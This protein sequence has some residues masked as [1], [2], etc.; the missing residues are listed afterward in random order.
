MSRQLKNRHQKYMDE[1]D[2]IKFGQGL[3]TPI[4]NRLLEEMEKERLLFPAYR[5]ICPREYIEASWK[6]KEVD[7]DLW[8][9]IVTFDR[10]MEIQRIPSEQTDEKLLGQGHPLDIAWQSQKAFIKRPEK[11][12][13]HPWKEYDVTLEYPDG[14]KTTRKCAWA[15]YEPWQIYHL[16]EITT[17][18]LGQRRWALL[19][20]DLSQYTYTM[21]MFKSSVMQYQDMHRILA[22]YQY[23]CQLHFERAFIRAESQESPFIEGENHREYKKNIHSEGVEAFKKATKE[24]WIEFIRDLSRLYSI[25]RKGKRR[26]E[27]CCA[28]RSL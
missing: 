14:A 6:R 17:T 25:S 26:L 22:D 4:S 12:S 24:R 13:F 18:I 7:A 1:D 19:R 23:R 5:T 11:E 28:I 27:I 3:K 10:E 9:E 16:D 20:G 2:F 15:F 8:K 21:P